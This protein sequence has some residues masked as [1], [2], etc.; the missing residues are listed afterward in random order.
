MN[1]YSIMMIKLRI[2]L[3]LMVGGG[4]ILGNPVWAGAQEAAQP[5]DPAAQG[6]VDRAKRDFDLATSFYQRKD[7]AQAADLYAQFRASYPTH[8]EANLALFREAECQFQMARLA[9]PEEAQKLYQE[10]YQLFQF[11]QNAD[12]QG[13]RMDETLLRMGQSLVELKK[14]EEAV[15]PL[16]RLITRQVSAE[17][18]APALFTLARAYEGLKKNAE[19]IENYKQLRTQFPESIYYAPATYLQAEAE[20]ERKNSKEALKLLQ[21]LTA[22]DRKIDISADPLL[23]AKALL[24]Q[25]R[26]LYA[27]RKYAEA[28]KAYTQV[29]S[30][31]PNTA[32]EQQALLG[33]AWCRFYTEDYAAARQTAEELLKR[34]LPKDVESSCL[35]L[36]GSSYYHQKV[37]QDSIEPF[38]KYLALA[39]DDELRREAWYQLTW[40]YLL[41]GQGAEALKQAEDLLKAGVPVDRASDLR[42]LS[43]RV[44][45][46]ADRW[47]LAE[48][49]FLASREMAGGQ[50]RDDAAYALAQSYF[51]Q[52]KY[53]QAIEAY[54]WFVTNFSKDDR[55]AE[56][57]RTSADAAL[58]LKRY[59]DASARIDRLVQIDPNQKDADKL[60][61]QQALS[62]YQQG[63]YEPMAKTLTHLMEVYP[64]S[65]Y[66]A[67]AQYWLGWIAEQ[68][69]DASKA[70]QLYEVFL[71]KYPTSQW[72]QEVT[73]RLAVLY[74][75]DGD[76]QKAYDLLVELLNSPEV[77]NLQPEICF[78]MALI[79]EQ[80]GEYETILKIMDTLETRNS[81]AAVHERISTA[82][83][84]A[85]LALQRWDEARTVCQT[86]LK[87][88]PQS[89]F[90]PEWLWGKGRCDWG[91]HKLEEAQA[92]FEEAL[93]ALNQI[94][95]TDLS[96]EVQLY[97]DTGEVLRE[98][99][100][101]R[102]A[103]REYQKVAQL[104]DHRQLSPLAFLRSAQCHEGLEELDKVRAD[105]NDLII[106][107]PDTDS[108]KE[109]QAWLA[110]LGPN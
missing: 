74:Y 38:R 5:P 109:A 61:Y 55:V 79:A 56:A 37:Y 4:L 35:Y 103:V 76:K 8:A 41:N 16:Q 23:P 87:K 13:P 42:Y 26:I 85:L 96:F 34:S 31:A 104:F 72:R 59:D 1:R 97:F 25:G 51:N 100:K 48:K 30:A 7:Y 105:L 95:S 33:L 60:L 98:G 66:A 21:E 40:A 82:R 94:G 46:E 43:G 77:S 88:W 11:L 68:A 39:A 9:K 107:Y 15:V 58:Q 110:R 6:Q 18:K 84:R 29:T 106:R 47:P 19:A 90:R 89:R 67:Q 102:A 2:P 52:Q 99:G 20:N 22:G 57:I 50:Y 71:Q 27:D 44:H 53:E 14:N 65:E 49:E 73:R 101:L 91:Q 92:N 12:P 80:R 70:K 36:I 3:V 64:N 62:Q 78:W 10:A 63:E 81:D 54:D 45:A 24:A 93:I 32:Q 75:R 83:C 86:A 69:Q 108:T 17:L 28:A